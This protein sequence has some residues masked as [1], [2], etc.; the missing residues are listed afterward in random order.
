MSLLVPDTGLL[1][2]MVLSFGIVF[3]ILAK[4]GFPVILKSVEQRK[5]YIT[6]SVEA[7]KEANSRLAE[8]KQ[9]GEVLLAEVRK[10]QKEILN[11]ALADKERILT[12]AHQKA[13][14]ETQRIL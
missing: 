12:E 2:W 11:E 7:A 6:N 10:Q 9:E 5:E 8:I 13:I 4:Y 1:F 3:F 14:E